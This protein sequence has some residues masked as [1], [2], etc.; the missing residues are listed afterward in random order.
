MKT[1]EKLKKKRI[2]WKDGNIPASIFFEILNTGNLSL[3]GNAPDDELEKVFDGIFDEYVQIDNNEK[4]IIWYQKKHKKSLLQSKISAAESI[5]YSITYMPLKRDERIEL[6]DLL[7]SIDG[8]RAKFDNDKPIIE[9]I[10]RIHTVVLGGLRNEL[11]FL[12]A[13]ERQQEKTTTY[14]F[15]KDLVNIQN[16]LGYNLPDTMS[17]RKFILL[18][19]SAQE[20]INAQKIKKHG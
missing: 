9:E 10:H 3:L 20:K 4:I 6:I 17:L 11:R 2:L 15:E 13:T 1:K 12:E 14:Y 19:K 8:L 16:V 18:K 5:L 7:N